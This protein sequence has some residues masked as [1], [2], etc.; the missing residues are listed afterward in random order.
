MQGVACRQ[1][2][3]YGHDR[4][5]GSKEEDDTFCT[6]SWPGVMVAQMAWP[7]C[8]Q[9]RGLCLESCMIAGYQTCGPLCARATTFAWWGNVLWG[10]AGNT[11]TSGHDQ[12]QRGTQRPSCRAKTQ[13]G[14][15]SSLQPGSG[16]PPATGMQDI[17][18]AHLE[19]AHKALGNG[20][21]T[22]G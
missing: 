14:S 17:Q 18:D 7:T 11:G 20:V 21:T 5:T 19:V 2:A 22:M 12:A 3:G 15:N 16:T 8:R 6:G 1:D 9:D 10:R 4:V 13:A